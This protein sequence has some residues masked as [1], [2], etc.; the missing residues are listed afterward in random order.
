MT[1]HEL[2]AASALDRGWT[3][4]AHFFDSYRVPLTR[5]NAT[6]LDLFFALFGH[7]PLW[8]KMLL[9]LRHKAVALF[10]LAV[11]TSAEVMSFDRKERYQVGDRIGVWSIYCLTEAELIAGRDN[12]HLDFRL[13][14]LSERKD[15]IECSVSTVCVVHNWFGKAYLCLVTPFHKV[16]MKVLFSRALRAGRL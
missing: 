4:G 10:G 3:R 1:E 11:P 8:M 5:E 9:I 14:I 6:P 16:G 12:T 2:P 15:R 13:S 7:H